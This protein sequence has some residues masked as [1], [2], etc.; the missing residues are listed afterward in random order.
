MLFSILR[1]VGSSVVAQSCL[2]LETL[3]AHQAHL[4]LGLSRQEYWSGLPFLFPGDIPDPGIEPRSPELQADSLPPELPIVNMFNLF[5][6]ETIVSM[7][8]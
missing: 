6:F 8:C 1:I 7:S 2:T 4:S 5:Y 3:W